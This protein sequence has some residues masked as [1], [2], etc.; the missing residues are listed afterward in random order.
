MPWRGFAASA[1]IADNNNV[2]RQLPNEASCVTT[3]LSWLDG[4]MVLA[5]EN[6]AYAMLLDEMIER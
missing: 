1:V 4:Q 6:D 3:D 5:L 2:S